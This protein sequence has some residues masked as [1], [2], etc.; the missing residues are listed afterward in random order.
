MNQVGSV[1]LIAA[2]AFAIYGGVA[3]AV[4]GKLRSLRVVKSAERATLAFL[5][6]VTL[7]VVALE[8]LI[9]TDDFHNSY[10]AANS[11]KD[12]PVY[13][14]VAVLWGGQEGSL[15]FWTWQ[16]AIYSALAVL[17]NRRKNR[18]LMPYV[19]AVLMG[20]AT[21]FTSLTFFAA[22]PFDELSLVTAGSS[23]PFLPPDGRGLS[24]SLQYHAMMIHPP[25]LYLGYVG[26]V[27]PFAFAMAALIT[28][29]LGDNWIRT[30]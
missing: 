11:N 24:P 6:T 25:I 21:F 16:L 13:Y 14:K 9:L 7:A 23:R 17:L 26:F 4:G 5:V 10:V 30:T 29:Q 8:Y 15:L 27:V 28:R 12:L 20:T 3:G 19:V 1:G 18:Q 2:L 22:N